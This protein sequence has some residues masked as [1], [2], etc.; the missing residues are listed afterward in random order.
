MWRFAADQDD[1]LIVNPSYTVAVAP[2][3]PADALSDAY[4]RGAP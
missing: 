3:G 4:M 2:W 1:E